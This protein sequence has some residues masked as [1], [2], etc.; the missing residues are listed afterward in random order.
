MK[1]GRM[2]KRR[3][4]Q[5]LGPAYANESRRFLFPFFSDCAAE[6]LGNESGSLKRDHKMN[7]GG[8]GANCGGAQ[9]MVYLGHGKC[10]Q[11]IC[12][13]YKH[14]PGQLRSCL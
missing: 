7:K 14:N 3:R 9:R 6:D 12:P 10:H 13:L 5:G 1:M 2:N 4:N 8:I 11:A